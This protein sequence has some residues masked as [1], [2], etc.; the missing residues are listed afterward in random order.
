MLWPFAAV[1]RLPLSGTPE[2]FLRA[3]PA[4]LAILALNYVWVLLGDLAF[5]E[6]SAADA[7]RRA[8]AAATPRS[9]NRKRQAPF[10]LGLSGRPEMAILWKN[11]ILLGR[12]ASARFLLRLLPIAVI[13]GVGLAG[14]RGRVGMTALVAMIGTVGAAMT[15]LFGPQ[16]MRNDLRQDLAQLPVLKVWPVRGAAL[17]RGE[18]LAPAI[19][20]TLLT[21]F[22]IAMGTVAAP[23]SFRVD[24]IGAFPGTVVLPALAAAVLAPGLIAVQ[25]VLHNGLAILFPAWAAIGASRSRGLDAFGQRLLMMAGIIVTLA[26]SLLPGLVAGGAVGYALY[27]LATSASSVIILVPAVVVLAVMLGECWLASEWLGRV[28]ERTDVGAVDASD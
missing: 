13:F 18:L 22:L 3:L 24:A 9:A 19:F 6:A 2:G 10:T 26:L 7:E 16:A 27:L 15:V 21:W 28:F 17:V 4:G 20:L 8:T 11:L 25:L 14:G 5:E 1:A 23:G 12:Y